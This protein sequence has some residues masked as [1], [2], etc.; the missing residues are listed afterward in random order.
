VYGCF[1]CKYVCLSTMCMR[2]LRR[3]EQGIGSPGTRVTD[4]VSCPVSVLPHQ[5]WGS[6]PGPLEEQSEP[7]L[8]DP[9]MCVC[10]C[11]FFFLDLC[12]Y[13]M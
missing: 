2:C 10:V 9:L 1:V 5:C 12:I 8:S 6:N 11:V 3:P 4:V 7:S 13:Y